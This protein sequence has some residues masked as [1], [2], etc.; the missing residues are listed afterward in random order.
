MKYGV[1]AAKARPCSCTLVQYIPVICDRLSVLVRR[2]MTTY[3]DNGT[4]SWLVRHTEV[5]TSMPLKT[6]TSRGPPPPI[7]IAASWSV[8][9][10][11]RKRIQVEIHSNG[12]HG[13]VDFRSG[14]HQ[15]SARYFVL[16]F[17]RDKAPA[18]CKIRAGEK[19]KKRD[20]SPLRLGSG[21]R[22][23]SPHGAPG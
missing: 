6:Y 13:D 12:S 20:S 5:K 22:P 19:K 21:R 15:K 16:S 9:R 3:M 14:G 7:A 1:L 2:S 10:G 8:N 23:S 17:Y 18:R 4:A 11:R